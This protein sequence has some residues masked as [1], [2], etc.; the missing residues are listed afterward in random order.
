MNSEVILKL[1][2]FNLELF[3]ELLS[4][5]LNLVNQRLESFL[6]SL[7]TVEFLQL[8]FLETNRLTFNRLVNKNMIFLIYELL[9]KM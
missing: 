6:L 2:A 8:F 1:Y 5:S 4:P 3:R 9:R 7:L